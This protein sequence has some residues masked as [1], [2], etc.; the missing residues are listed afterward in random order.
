MTLAVHDP[1]FSIDPYFFRLYDA[2]KYHCGYFTADVWFDMTGQDIRDALGDLFAAPLA[3][4][5]IKKRHRAAFSKLPQPVSPCLAFFYRPRA[6][7]HV[8][9]WFQGRVLHI[10]SKGVEW[11]PPEVASRGFESMEYFL[12]CNM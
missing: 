7:P 10:H 5:K 8:G 6:A 11:Q 9:V 4:R 2:V 1:A 12:P 3:A